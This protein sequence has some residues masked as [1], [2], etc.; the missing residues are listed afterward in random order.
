MFNFK[1]NWKVVCTH[2]TAD[3]ILEN[4]NGNEN[5]WQLSG[6]LICN[7]S[8][9]TR[10][11]IHLD[12]FYGYLH[13]YIWLQDSKTL[14]A[15]NR[16]NRLFLTSESNP[17]E[18]FFGFGEQFTYFDMKGK[19]VPIWVS[20]Q[21]V[22][23]GEQPLTFCADLTNGGAGGNAFTSYAPMPLYIT[24]QMRNFFLWNTN[25]SVFDLRQL[26]RVQVELWSPNLS[27]IFSKAKLPN[28]LLRI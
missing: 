27:Q 19:R 2:Q 18:H 3:T 6:Y 14:G 22:G 24:S 10:Y 8:T 20:E 21:G 11:N 23:R 5:T 17:D 4:I 15:E 26:D 28:K 16:F 12:N 13:L 9:T 7:N 1:D 25:F